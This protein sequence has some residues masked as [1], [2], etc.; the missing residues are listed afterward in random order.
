MG[1]RINA[2]R[3]MKDLPTVQELIDGLKDYI[4]KARSYGYRV[5]VGTL[6]PMGG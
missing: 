6:L 2:F 3:P 4:S 5:Y 1:A